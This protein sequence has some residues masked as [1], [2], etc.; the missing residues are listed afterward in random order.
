MLGSENITGIHIVYAFLSFLLVI[1]G[2][3]FIGL[4]FGYLC[5]FVTK[6]T[7]NNRIIE[8]TFVFAF[9][10]LSYLSAESCHLSGIIA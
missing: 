10:Y 7:V 5:S 4:F 2:A 1:F 6:Y 9:C 3:L 8:P